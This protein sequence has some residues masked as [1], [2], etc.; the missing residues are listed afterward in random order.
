MTVRIAGCLAAT[1]S[2]A[3]TSTTHSWLAA[4]L[5]PLRARIEEA[6]QHSK[7][8]ILAAKP[9]RWVVAAPTGG[10]HTATVVVLAVHSVVFLC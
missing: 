1:H 9:A 4:H 10:G 5:E 2:A 7:A 6:M 8:H 3:E